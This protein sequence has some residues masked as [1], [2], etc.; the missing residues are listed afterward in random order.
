MLGIQPGDRRRA[1]HRGGATRGSWGSDCGSVRRKWSGHRERTGCSGGKW[2]LARRDAPATDVLTPDIET[3]CC[4]DVTLLNSIVCY[5]RRSI[6]LGWP[7]RHK[8]TSHG[9]SRGWCMV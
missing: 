5:G 2:T 6:A 7:G 8:K 4:V 3:G 9:I 1:A